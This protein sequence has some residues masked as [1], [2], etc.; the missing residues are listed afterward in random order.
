MT[1][2]TQQKEQGN[3]REVRKRGTTVAARVPE[4]KWAANREMRWG[5]RPTALGGKREKK[6]KNK[7]CFQEKNARRKETSRKWDRTAGKSN[8]R[9][10]IEGKR[11]LLGVWPLYRQKGMGGSQTDT[12]IERRKNKQRRRGLK[13][14]DWSAKREGAVEHQ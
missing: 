8:G 9:V 1:S 3:A 5:G 13:G 2:P 14:R 4:E 10:T 6:I 7:N 11:Y 12:E